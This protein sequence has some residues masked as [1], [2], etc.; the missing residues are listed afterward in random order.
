MM[1]SRR[2][3]GDLTHRPRTAESS[4]VLITQRAGGDE[5][6]FLDVTVAANLIGIARQ[7]HG[8]SMVLGIEIYLDL[9]DQLDVVVDQ[10]P[11]VTPLLGLAEDI[12][13]APAKTF[14]LLERFECA[15]HP[16]AELPLLQL[17][18]HR[19]AL[20]DGRRRQVV[21]DGVAVLE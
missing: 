13:R 17:A 18:G 8:G 3:S 21:L 20:G 15:Q 12:E 10:L 7:L 11:L 14:E 5:A 6:F 4:Q 16:G 9:L 1:V 19:I 2:L